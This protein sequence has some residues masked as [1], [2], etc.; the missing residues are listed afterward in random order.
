MQPLLTR[1]TSLLLL[2]LLLVWFIH[3][4]RQ[5]QYFLLC[6]PI[7]IKDSHCR[8]LYDT[9]ACTTITTPRRG[10][11]RVWPCQ[12]PCAPHC[13]LQA[14]AVAVDLWKVFGQVPYHSHDWLQHCVAQQGTC[15]VQGLYC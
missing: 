5:H 10:S 14:A 11:A 9:D 13:H 12:R 15:G 6:A 7:H 1:Y 4:Y 2:P 8:C 3:Q